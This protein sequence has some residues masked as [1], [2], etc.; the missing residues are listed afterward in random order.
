MLLFKEKLG[1]TTVYSYKTIERAYSDIEVRQVL[2]KVFELTNVPV[3]D[4]EH[5]FGPDAT[6]HATS[7]KQ[8]Y[9]TDRA[10]DQTS[11]ATRKPSI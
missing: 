5:E 9:E 3:A 4:L 2:E 11:K 10:K 8:N 1:F 7:C 6:G